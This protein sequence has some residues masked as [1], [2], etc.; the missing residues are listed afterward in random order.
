MTRILALLFLGF[1]GL[2]YGSPPKVNGP[3]KANAGDV[4]EIEIEEDAAGKIG[5]H[6]PYDVTDVY[7]REALPRREK[8]LCLIIQPKKPGV[9]RLTVWTAG[10]RVGTSCVVDATGGVVNPPTPP[11]PP[12]PNPPTPNPPVT[13]TVADAWIIV[14]E[15]TSK[16]TPVSI[17]VLNDLTFWKSLP[18]EGWRFYD[19][20][21]PDVKRMK[22]DVM[23]AQT[24]VP[25]PVLMAV[26]SKGNLVRASSLP[27]TTEGVRQFVKDAT[28]K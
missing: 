11:T 28:G 22:Y 19:K 23:A 13:P 14:V 18:V 3:F 25:L 2:A 6:N 9:Y 27:S 16:R 4:V 21:S 8:T 1:G 5:F 20:D 17:Q 10:E 7:V 26:D 15:E 24:N 12:G